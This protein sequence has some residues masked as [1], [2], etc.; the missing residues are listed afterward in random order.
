VLDEPT[1]ALDLSVQAQILN[2]LVS[3]QRDFE[4]AYLFISH[5][6]EVVKYLSDEVAVL[7]AGRIVEHGSVGAVTGSPQAEYTRTLLAA[8]PVADPR[9]QRQRRQART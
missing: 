7:R 8:A 5:D 6:I 3:L 9:A 4:L 1:S 2:L